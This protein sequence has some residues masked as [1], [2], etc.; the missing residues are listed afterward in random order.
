MR[1][2]FL[3]YI[4]LIAGVLFAQK[5]KIG[6]KAPGFTLKDVDGKERSLSEFEG[7][8]VVLEWVNYDCPFVRKHYESGNMPALQKKYTGEGVVWLSI[9]SSA[10]GAQ[11]NFSSSE[12]KEKAAGYGA[13]F[14]DYLEDES[15][16]V[17]K[18]YGAK[19][20]PHMFVINPEGILVYAGGIDDKPST[21]KDDI[22]IAI[23]YV[24][25]ALN[26]IME[27]KPVE[28]KTARP[29]GCSVKYKD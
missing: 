25:A 19:T 10:P 7:K 20:T 13:K 15:G 26:S 9:C 29:Y 23:N 3:I 18:E 16:K 11:G 14:T 24:A 27:G 21:D 6:E 8:T 28:I 5:A 17:G 22:P 4:V 12:I 2:K 1:F